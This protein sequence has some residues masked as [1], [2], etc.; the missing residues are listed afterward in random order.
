MLTVS[1]VSYEDIKQGL[2][3]I[4]QSD[5]S[6]KTD[7]LVKQVYFPVKDTYHLLSILTPSGVL[8]VLK[9]RVDA[10][11]F[12]DS[13]KE[14]KEVRRKNEHHATGYDDL[15][16]LTVTAYGGTQPQNISAQNSQNAG[17]AYLLSSV[18]PSL[19][20]RDIRL[21]TKDF[22][23]NS[24]RPFLFKEHF[25]ALNKLMKC[26]VNNHLIRDQISMHINRIVDQV[27]QQI[28]KIR[29]F[30]IGWSN[31]DYYLSLPLSQRIFLD[32]FHLDSRE[33]DTDWIDDISRNFARWILQTYEATLKDNYLALS[34]NE[35][36]HIRRFVEVAIANDKEFLL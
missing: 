2:L 4:K 35:L 30:E 32:D 15:F 6:I 5:S 1:T 11:R 27:L 9:N 26:E 20:K 8:S 10:I 21:P 33:S 36:T 29:Q 12:S 34:D 25:L 22:F 19:T 7:R 14:A 13:T 28:F 31:S 17:R 16:D 23:R 18:P 24:L 3:S